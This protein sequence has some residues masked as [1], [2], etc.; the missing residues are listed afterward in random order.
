MVVCDFVFLSVTDVSVYIYLL[1]DAVSIMI[2]RS[3]LP[4]RVIRVHDDSMSVILEAEL[5]ISNYATQS[6]QFEGTATLADTRLLPS[7]ANLN[8]PAS[9]KS[10][11]TT[12]KN[13]NLRIAW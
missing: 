8:L 2:L 11:L 6:L 5:T 12:F 10:S 9:S 13:C 1:P 4:G 3:S 7:D